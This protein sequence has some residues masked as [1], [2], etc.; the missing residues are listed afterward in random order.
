MKLGIILITSILSVGCVYQVADKT[1]IL[2]AEQFCKELGGVKEI[3]IH[4]DSTE[5]VEC[6]NGDYKYIHDIKLEVL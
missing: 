6:L 4:F 1:D 3:M 5:T 2:K